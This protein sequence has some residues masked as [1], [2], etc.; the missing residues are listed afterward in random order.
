MCSSDL[1]NL[2]YGT[3]YIAQELY[4][5]ISQDERNRTYFHELGNILSAQITGD[6]R[7]F[8]DPNGIGI[9]YKDPDTGARLEKCIFGSVP[10]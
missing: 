5:A 4:T 3:V 2:G 6:A 8:G 1:S 10:F 9:H 7:H